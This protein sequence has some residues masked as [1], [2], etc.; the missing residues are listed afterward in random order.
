VALA[1]F[2]VTPNFV[3]VTATSMDGPFAVLPTLAAWLFLRAL[4]ARRGSAALAVL[5][6]IAGAAAC[7]MTYAAL[8]LGPLLVLLGLF[9]ARARWTGGRRLLASLALGAA[10]AFAVY[11]ALAAAGYDAPAALRASIAHDHGL[12]DTG[13]ETT[14]RHLSIGV[15]NLAAFLTGLGVALTALWL[16]ATA[17]AVR[18][19]RAGEADP[20]AL[21]AAVTVL[22][23]AFSTL[24]TLEVERVWLFMVPVVV[25]A[26]ARHLHGLVEET[27]RLA[28]L[29]TAAAL[30]CLQ[31]FA[32][33]A[34]LRTGW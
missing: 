9:A 7:F 22:A 27:G 5:A 21:A 18:R 30:Q 20:L 3:M 19:F 2:V 6:G 17:G 33:E 12:M 34:L 24:F 28:V 31:L 25:A 1:L 11:A 4:R 16:R 23:M 10:G 26:A 8:F 29:R 32:S 14:W 15:A 13:R